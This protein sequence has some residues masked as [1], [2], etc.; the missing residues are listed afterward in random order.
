MKEADMASRLV[1]TCA[2]VLAAV[3]APAAGMVDLNGTWRLDAFPQP[4]GGAIR[5]V[6][7]NVPVQTFEAEVPGCCE[8]DLVKAGLLPDPMVSTNAFAFR[9][10]Q[11]HQWLY[12][13]TFAAPRRAEEGERCVLVFGGID[14]L[15]DVFLNGEKIGSPENMLIP[16]EYD[17]TGKLKEGAENTVQVLIRPVLLA[18]R[19][20]SLGER[21]YTMSGSTSHEAFRK[22]PYMYGWDT[23]PH[24]PV[25]GIWRDV[26]LEVRPAVRVEEPVWIVQSLN[27]A[28]RSAY[29]GVRC[30][31]NAPFGQYYHARVRCSLSRNGREV[32]ANERPLL[33]PH[34]RFGIGV[35]NADFWWPRGMGEA[36]LYDATIEVRAE[37]GS[38]LARDVRKIGLRMVALEYEDRKLPERP[39]RFLFKI[40][41]EPVFI[42]GTD[43]IPLD[44]IPSR[45]KAHLPD[46]LALAADLNCNLIRVWGGGVY[47]PEEFFA[48]CDELGLMVWQDFM[49]ACTV[50]PQG[51]YF[52]KAIRD[53][54]RSVVVQFRNHPSIVLWAGDNENDQAATWGVGRELAWDP[55]KNRITRQVIPEV[56]NEFD[57]TRPYLPSSPY[58]SPDAH[59]GKVEAAE[60]HLWSGPRAWWK[61][62]YYTDNPCWFCSEGGGHAIP[63]RSTFEKMMPADD[64]ERIW[65]NPEVRDWR[66]LEWTL[67]WRY[68]AT[69]PNLEPD[70]YPWNR[71]D[72]ILKQTAALFGDVP[73]NLDLLVEQSQSAQV[74]AIKFQMELFR[75]QKFKKKGGFVVWNLRDGWPTISD[76]VSDYYGNKKK[77]YFALK[78]AQQTVLAMISESH[79]LLVVN[80]SREPANGRVKVTD[81]ATGAVVF[82]G[83]YSAPA[84][85]VLDL[86]YVPWSGQG[87]FKIAYTA[88]GGTF[89]NHYLYG[90][91]PFAWDAFSKWMKD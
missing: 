54:V 61:T 70:V 23:M 51:E 37:D 52:A 88:P 86:A 81:A 25:S 75:S 13:R 3:S 82:D 59:A 53:E 4:A 28:K 89:R 5:T 63:C 83:E 30:R 16:H 39:G 58:I 46:A 65:T 76:A 71:N 9:A 24:L 66:K 22:A 80:D 64:V 57:A 79:R 8:M 35:S 73:R 77:S 68:R 43:W 27:V 87:V 6:P 69:C 14:T 36:A 33:S 10:W 55:N 18:S 67:Q 1:A 41:G 91:P 47:E 48:G 34:L 72:L 56:V 29:V 78:A 42:R 7:V 74:E 12:T 38:I 84:N 49:M 40:N 50:P 90:Q 20:V 17:V 60:D 44:P 15:A 31:I 11:G 19:D 21:G 32:A 45:Q 62:P 85:G 2:I 26:R